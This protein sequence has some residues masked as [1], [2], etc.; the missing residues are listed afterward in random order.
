MDE[1]AQQRAAFSRTGV[2]ATMAHAAQLRD[3]FAGWMTQQLALDPEKTADIVLAVNEALAN[4]AEHAYLHS[5]RPGPMHLQ[6]EHDPELATLTVRVTDEG[7]W[8]LKDPAMAPNPGRGRGT[9]L[10]RALTDRSV[11]DSTS[12]GTEVLLQWDHVGARP[13]G[14][15]R[16]IQDDGLQPA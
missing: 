15:I 1:Q 8:H 16:Q 6:A 9:L 7:R 2:V 3:E 14:S 13:S 10:I 12:T 11:V 5:A 4:A